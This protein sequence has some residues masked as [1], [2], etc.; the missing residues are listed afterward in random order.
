VLVGAAAA[1]EQ[2]LERA[3]D[4]GV[5]VVTTYGMSETCGGCVYDGEPLDGVS[6]DLVEVDGDA[7]PVRLGGPTLFSGYRLRP[8]LTAQ[9]F[10]SQGRFRTGDLGRWDRGRLVV[11]GRSDDVI[12]SGGEKVVPARVEAVLADEFRGGGAVTVR[13]WCVVGVP[14]PQWGERVVAVGAAGPD[15]ELGPIER[16]RAL[17]AD[18]LP[19]AW[20][21]RALVRVDALP[22][23]ASGK[24]DRAQVRALAVAALSAGAR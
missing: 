17:A 23:L 8:D 6:V 22:M 24:V 7:G 4:A 16:V 13:E 11:L 12:I 10:D 18:R 5:A 20:L 15:V 19:A 1:P 14:D 2:L 21:P 9:A 3:R